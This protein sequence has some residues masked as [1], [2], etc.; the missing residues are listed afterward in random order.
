MHVI[1][2]FSWNVR[3]VYIAHLIA[4]M[5]LSLIAFWVKLDS[6][7][8]LFPEATDGTDRL[9]HDVLLLCVAEH[10]VMRY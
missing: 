1:Q 5:P 2:V 7:T 9:W 3:L 10:H 6:P 8:R 4:C